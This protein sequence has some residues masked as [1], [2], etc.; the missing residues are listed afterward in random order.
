MTIKEVERLTGMIRENIRFYEKEG[1]LEPKRDSNGYREY[2][3]EDV[4]TL[5]RIKLLRVLHLPLDEVKKIMA[6]KANLAEVMQEH[7]AVLE[8]AISQYNISKDVC[9]AIYSKKESMQS[10]DADRYFD[11]MTPGEGEEELKLDVIDKEIAPVARGAARYL[12]LAVYGMVVVAALTLLIPGFRFSRPALYA[13]TWIAPLLLT[14]IIEPFMLATFGG[15]PGKLVMG[16][17][18]VHNDGRRLTYKEALNR[19]L[20]LIHY[21]LGFNIAP[22]NAYRFVK[23]YETMERGEL[24][25]WEAQNSV[26]ADPR[27][28]KL[29]HGTLY[30]LTFAAV[31]FLAWGSLKLA[32][33]IEAKEALPNR[34][35]LTLEQF[36]ENFNAQVEEYGNYKALIL[37]AEGEWVVNEELSEIYPDAEKSIAGKPEFQ[38]VMDGDIVTEIFWEQT[39]NNISDTPP[40]HSRDIALSFLAYAGARSE[41][42][43]NENI[44]KEL[45]KYISERSNKSFEFDMYGVNTCWEVQHSGFDTLYSSGQ[46]YLF[47]DDSG[48]NSYTIKFTMKKSD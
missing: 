42:P 48:V 39:M 46:A 22:Y 47:P 1:L 33:N 41:K 2:S 26:L 38:Y 37:N 4:E 31:I 35:D 6:G 28:R 24:L 11:M 5:K 3:E 19:T 40:A 20:S 32:D 27:P 34:G 9:I 8:E 18:V 25:P 44:S 10:L 17:R 15:T 7:L 30:V 43:L 45:I 21:G 12:D 16:M 14:I 23:S 36:V 13:V 29:L